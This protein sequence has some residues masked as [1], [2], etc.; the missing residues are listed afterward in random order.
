MDQNIMF[1]CVLVAAEK[2]RKKVV[3]PVNVTPVQDPV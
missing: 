1:F 3:L 2:K